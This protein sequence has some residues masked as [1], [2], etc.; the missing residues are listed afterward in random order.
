MLASRNR[1]KKSHFDDQLLRSNV[2]LKF[3]KCEFHGDAFLRNGK[4]SNPDLLISKKYG[5]RFFRFKHFNYKT[6]F[7]FE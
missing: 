3:F 5:Q 1:Q 4:C 6:P 2:P 7:F